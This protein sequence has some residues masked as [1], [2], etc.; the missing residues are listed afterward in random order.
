MTGERRGRHGLSVLREGDAVGLHPVRQPLGAARE[1][2]EARRSEEKE[3]RKK[4][5]FGLRD[6]WEL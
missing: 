4:K 2:W 1:Q 3:R 6:P 5:E